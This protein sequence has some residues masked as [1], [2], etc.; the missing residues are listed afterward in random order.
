M[1]FL[2]VSHRFPGFVRGVGRGL[3]GSVLKPMSKVTEAISDVGSGQLT[4]LDL[5]GF[6]GFFR[7]ERWVGG[8]KHFEKM[9]P[10]LVIRC[11]KLVE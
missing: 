6:G 4:R 3:A 1:A 8:V 5:E 10:P 9:V 11:Y 7:M 2:S